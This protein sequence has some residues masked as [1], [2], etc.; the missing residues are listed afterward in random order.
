MSKL[1]FINSIGSTR[2]GTS[3]DIT[4]VMLHREAYLYNLGHE[5]DWWNKLQVFLILISAI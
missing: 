4:G 2:D 5:L 1:Y 3:N